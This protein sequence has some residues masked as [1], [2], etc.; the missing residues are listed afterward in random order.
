MARLYLALFENYMIDQTIG[1]FGDG[2][3]DAKRVFYLVYKFVM[4]SVLKLSIKHSYN[5]II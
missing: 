2:I 4:N 1:M 3:F 5:C